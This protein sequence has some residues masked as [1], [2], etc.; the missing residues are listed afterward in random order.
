MMGDLPVDLYD[1]DWDGCVDEL[2]GVY[3]P[4]DDDPD[5]DTADRI[6]QLLAAT[7]PEGWFLPYQDAEERDVSRG[8]RR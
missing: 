5:T 2:F 3:G 4:E 1:Y 7:H 8:Y 6:D